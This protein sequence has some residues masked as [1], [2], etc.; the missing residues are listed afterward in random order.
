M[1]ALIHKEIA[2]AQ[3][4]SHLKP[5][6]PSTHSIYM[7]VMSLCRI[8]IE[9]T[10]P[11]HIPIDLDETLMLLHNKHRISLFELRKLTESMQKS[12]VL[13]NKKETGERKA[14]RKSFLPFCIG[15]AAAAIAGVAVCKAATFVYSYQ[16]NE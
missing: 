2:N 6:I 7:D 15:I 8:A 4:F 14:R 1:E 9:K 12:V 3:I 11:T 16:R 10:A 13:A 5:T